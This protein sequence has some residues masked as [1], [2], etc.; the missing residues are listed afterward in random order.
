MIRI[1]TLSILL[2]STL[3]GSNILSYNIY[4][5]TDRVDVMLTFDTPYRGKI[6]KSRY[7]SK[8]VLKLYNAKIESSK[9]KRL[10]SRFLKSISINPMDGYTQIVASVPTA[11]IV[12]K[13]SKTADGYGLRL[14]FI[15][16]SALQ[17]ASQIKQQ[18][19]QSVSEDKLFPNLPTKKRA[20]ISTSYYVVVTL[21]LIAVIVMLI[22]KRKL[23][24]T[25][26][27]SKKKTGWLFKNNAPKAPAMQTTY[28]HTSSEDVSI[29]FQKRLDEHNSVVMLDFHEQSYLV[30]V[31]EHNNLLLDK[32]HGATPVTQEEFESLLEE[33]NSELDAFL[34]VE[35]KADQKV[36]QDTDLLRIFS[37]KASNTP[38]E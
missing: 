28:K 22:L 16:K 21:L 15:K 19:T 37:D 11:D 10:S 33:K 7:S 3:F 20:D 29:R 17:S 30:L 32:F 26:T 36:H 35:Q 4:D 2:L 13:A 25:S 34:K 6:L 38:Y 23:T 1:F 9:I 8:I 12:L 14:R 18:A 27:V 24:Q 5:R 31:G